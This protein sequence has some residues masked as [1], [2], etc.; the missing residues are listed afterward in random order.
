MDLAWWLSVPCLPFPGLP[1]IYF[2]LTVWLRI[3]FFCHIE[4]FR[5]RFLC[6]YWK[7]G[8]QIWYMALAWWLVSC[9]PFPGL[10]HIY[11]LFTMW[12]RIFFM[13]AVL[14]IFVTDKTFFTL[15]W[16]LYHYKRIEKMSIRPTVHIDIWYTNLIHE[17]VG[18]F[19]A[20][21]S[22]QHL[23]VICLLIWRTPYHFWDI[24]GQKGPMP[25]I[26]TFL[27]Y[28]IHENNCVQHQTL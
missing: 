27:I 19:L 17:R 25:E 16:V 20:R 21:R 6:W 4:N 18:V 1:H 9:L 12:L 22:V 14:K 8:F 13:F 11:F 28:C 26:V 24:R 2:L 15:K 5:Y 7:K 23:V 3:F 10:P